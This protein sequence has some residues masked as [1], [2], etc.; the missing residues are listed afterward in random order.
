V[1][2]PEGYQQSFGEMELVEKNLISHRAIAVKKL[3]NFMKV[4]YA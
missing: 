4:K 3:I 2:Q 1:F